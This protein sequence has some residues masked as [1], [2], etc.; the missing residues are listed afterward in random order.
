MKMEFVKNCKEREG[1]CTN[2]PPSP[3]CRDSPDDLHRG[4]F[5]GYWGFMFLS[6]LA[7]LRRGRRN[8][9]LKNIVKLA[10]ALRTSVSKLTAGL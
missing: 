1:T 3:I 9:S 4:F 5:V 10:G 7:V 6:V 8:P 2:A